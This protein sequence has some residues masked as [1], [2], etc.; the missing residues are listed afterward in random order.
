MR[1]YLGLERDEAVRFT[2]DG[3]YHPKPLCV[4]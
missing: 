4:K 2:G 1:L 3:V